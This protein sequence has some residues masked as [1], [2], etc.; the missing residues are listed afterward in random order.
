MRQA[1]SLHNGKSNGIICE[2]SE[3]RL[4]SLACQEII[5]SRSKDLHAYRLDLFRDDKMAGE[6]SHLCRV[7]FQVPDN[8]PASI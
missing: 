6:L 4:E 1:V 7:F 3:G 8:R 2:Q 5:K